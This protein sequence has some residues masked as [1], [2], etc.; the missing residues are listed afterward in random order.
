ML[1]KKEN[2]STKKLGWFIVILVY[3]CEEEIM[4]NVSQGWR[5]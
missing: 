5:K 3:V 2:N 1:P 4:Q